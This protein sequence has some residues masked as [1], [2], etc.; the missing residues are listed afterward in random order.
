MKKLLIVFGALVA[1]LVIA[2]LVGPGLV[3][4]NSYKAEITTRAKEAAGLDLHI[5]GDLELAVLPTPALVANKVRLSN[6]DGATSN[7]MVRLKSLQVRVALG[8]L[9]TGRVQVQTIRLVEPV[10]E[11]ERFADGRWNVLEALNSNQETTTVQDAQPGTGVVSAGAS[12]TLDVRLDNFVI[13][14]GTVIYRDAVAGTVEKIDTINAKVAAASLNGPFDSSGSLVARGIPLSY[15]VSLGNII[16]GRTVPVSF[17]VGIL[18][19]NGQISA[20][21][22]ITGL[23]EIPTFKGKIAGD[24]SR[25]SDLV[26]GISGVG[27]LPGMLGQPFAFQAEVVA[28]AAGA[29]LTDLKITLGTTELTGAANAAI[30]ETV[31]VVIDLSTPSVNLDEWLSLAA[32][33]RPPSITSTSQGKTSGIESATSAVT[34]NMPAK[35]AAANGAVGEG[36]DFVLPD[37]ISG[38]LALSAD[39]LTLR[40]GLVRQARVNVELANGEMTISQLA[41]QLP[42]GADVAVFG[43]L[44]PVGGKPQFEGQ[45]EVSVSDLRGAVDWIGVALPPLPSDRL[46]K[47]T[48]AGKLKA[49]AQQVQVSGIDLQFDS[50]R[51]TGAATVNLSRRPSFGVDLTLDRL[52]LDAY[53]VAPGGRGTTTTAAATAVGEEAQKSPAAKNDNP[54]T[55]ALAGLKFLESFD[56]NIKAGIETLV[57]GGTSIKDIA[58]DG[59]LYDKSL[60]LKRLSVNKLVGSSVSLKG[61]FGNL[62][63]IPSLKDVQLDGKITDLPRLM[64]MVG[65]VPPLEAKSVGTIALKTRLDGPLLTPQVNVDLRGAGATAIAAGKL[66]L[67]PLIGGFDGT[68]DIR[69]KSLTGLL[70]SLGVEYQPTGKLGGL[71]LAANV[72]ADISSLTL[73]ELTGK[74]GPVALQGDITVAIDGPRPKITARLG[75]GEI[76]VDALM[77]ISGSAFLDDLK[78]IVPAAFVLPKVGSAVPSF[79]RQ[80]ALKPGKWPTDPIDMSAL[81]AFDAD[82]KVKS[83]AIVSGNYRVENADIVAAVDGG[84]LRV[85]RLNGG[86]FGGVFDAKGTVTAA[87]PIQVKTAVTLKGVNVDKA[88]L[89][90]TGEK[91]AT[92]DAE[93]NVDLETNGNSVAALIGGMNGRGTIALKKLDVKTGGKGSAMSAAL[94]LVAG[95]N[96]IG[97]A[98]SGNKAGGAAADITGSFDITHGVA[99]SND[100]KLISGMGNGRAGG[101]IDLARWLVDVAGQVDLSQNFISQVLNQGAPTS[102][103]VPFSIRGR[104]DAPTIKLDTSKLLTSGLPIP[105]LDKVLK[106]KGIGS[107]LQNVLPG[108]GGGTQQPQQ[109]APDSPPPP[110]S[111]PPPPSPQQQQIQPKDLLKGLLKGLGG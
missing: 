83:S 9:L 29:G 64:R 75:T 55:D 26:H 7:E 60:D 87:D 94:G 101:T 58:F 46:H 5:D 69:H 54:I 96:N 84:V 95:L 15:D 28:N 22:A 50:S 34:L 10:I 105:G 70:R 89:A 111:E 48:L 93:M 3:D 99:R 52:N 31:D 91:M 65:S 21:G 59:V 56:A 24:S 80:V 85:S 18:P 19:E 30:A 39:S 90:V 66:S 37:G 20:S 106:K 1:F 71:N 33:Q 16:E 41:A 78:A 43:F 49:T 25:L 36:G 72:K 27:E 92:G 40:G 74:A 104:L 62:S 17:S 45:V 67:L 2:V 44:S 14:N 8:P 61:V 11:L 109:P 13:E 23:N 6:P 32:V 12:D 51:L 53:L 82:L 110:G 57:Y 73:R 63:G 79:R 38:S 103:A 102:T 76:N 97:G 108:L 42:G 88:L 107:L 77:P 47:M 81:N 86:L 68:L 35:P 98:L 100:L 4:W